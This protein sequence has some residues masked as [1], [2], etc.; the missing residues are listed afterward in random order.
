MKKLFLA[1]FAVFA[2]ASVNAQ[3]GFSAKAGFNNVSVS[4]D[5]ASGSES[6]FY[7]GLGYQFEISEQFAIE[8]AVLYSAV[9]DFNALYVPV[10]AKYSISD[11]FSLMAGPQ[12]NYILEDVEQ[13]EFGIDLG[14]GASYNITENFYAEARYAFQVSRDLEGVDINTLTL[15]V[16]YRF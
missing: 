13:G 1:A 16:G 10:M 8:P 6:G 4:F 11:D 14:A 15:G 9:S 5:G 12:V 2:F 3:E 7:V